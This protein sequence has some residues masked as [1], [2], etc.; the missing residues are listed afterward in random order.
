MPVLTEFS[1]RSGL[2][3]Y[4][5]LGCLPFLLQKGCVTMNKKEETREVVAEGEMLP[6]EKVLKAGPQVLS[7]RELIAVLLRTGTS[8]IDVKE[9]AGNVLAASNG[10]GLLGLKHMSLQEFMSIRGIGEVKAI[11]L[12][13]ACEMA[14]RMHKLSAAEKLDFSSPSTIADYYM[15]DMRHLETERLIIAMLDNRCRLLSDEV[16][17]I[18]TVNASLISPR[19]VLISVL[20]AGAVSFVVLHNHPSGDPQPS[21]QD[22]TVTKRLQRAGEIVGI[23]LTDHII[24]GDKRYF[25]FVESGCLETKKE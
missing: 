7:D 12:T 20:R 6:Y 3:C 13:C 2:L 23:P 19:E 11:Q 25:S 15:E 10:R 22:R 14:R 18:G 21:I 17:T 16:L 4:N 5:M 9:L 8:G 1:V 24:I